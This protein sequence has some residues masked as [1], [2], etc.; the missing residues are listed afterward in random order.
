M[1][2]IRWIGRDES[3]EGV[4]GAP[5]H[6]VERGLSRLLLTHSFVFFNF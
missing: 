5:E 6:F 2:S 4:M 1:I 3:T